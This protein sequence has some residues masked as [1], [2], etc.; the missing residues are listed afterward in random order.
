[1]DGMGPQLEQWQTCQ[2]QNREKE[3]DADE[4]SAKLTGKPAVLASALIKIYERSKFGSIPDHNISSPSLSLL[5]V[6]T[7]SERRHL[8]S[9]EPSISL[10]IR[11]LLDLANRLD[12]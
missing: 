11:R 1:M 12:E 3:L 10:R 8:F 4:F 6:A 7:M 9:K 2:A 5:S